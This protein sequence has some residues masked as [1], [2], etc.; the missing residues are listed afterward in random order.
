MRDRR[1]M[2]FLPGGLVARFGATLGNVTGPAQ[3]VQVRR[4]AVAER[5]NCEMNVPA[6]ALD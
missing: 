4:I 6:A 3:S 5:P 1:C 2:R